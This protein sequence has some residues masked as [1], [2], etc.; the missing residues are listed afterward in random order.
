LPKIGGA[1][2]DWVVDTAVALKWIVSEHDSLLA[3]AFY[4]SNMRAGATLSILDLGLIEASNGLWKR[5]HRKL[6]TRYETISAYDTLLKMPLDVL[7]SMMSDRRALEIACNYDIAVYDAH[8]VAAVEAMGCDG[9]TADEPLVAKVG[10][11]FPS[12]KLLKDWQPSP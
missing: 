12:I 1:M 5:F 8:F 7:E 6:M 3:R 4:V 10:K 11:D 2:T 9:I